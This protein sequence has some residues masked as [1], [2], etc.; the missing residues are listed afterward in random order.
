MRYNLNEMDYEYVEDYVF[1]SMFSIG[2]G[3]CHQQDMSFFQASAE[4]QQ[5][6]KDGLLKCKKCQKEEDK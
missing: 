3:K 5:H 2:C 4:L 1:S 6:I